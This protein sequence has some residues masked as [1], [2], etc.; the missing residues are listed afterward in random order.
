M[1]Q[2]EKFYEYKENNRYEVKKPKVV[3]HK[4]YGKHIPHLLIQMVVLSF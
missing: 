1:F 2:I 4:V 3:C